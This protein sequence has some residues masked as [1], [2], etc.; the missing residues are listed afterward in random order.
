VW[1]GEEPWYPEEG[2]QLE[3]LFLCSC[4]L[5]TPAGLCSALQL[6]VRLPRLPHLQTGSR[7]LQRRRPLLPCD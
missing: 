7:A 5:Y 4:A 2:P 6:I 3:G 1:D